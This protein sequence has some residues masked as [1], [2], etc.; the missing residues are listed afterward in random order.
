MERPNSDPAGAGSPGPLDEFTLIE[1]LRARFEAAAGARP[2]SGETWIGD[3]A[4]V[5][6]LGGDRLV[7]STDLVVEGVHVDLALGGPG[8]AGYKALM[9][10]LSDLAAMGARPRYAV[11]SMAAPPGTGLERVGEG[12]ADAAA[13]TG[14]RVV[15]GDLSAAPVLVISVAAVGTLEGRSDSPALLR[16]GATPGDTLFVTG[17]LG[18]AAAGLR[19][20]RRGSACPPGLA[21]RWLRPKARIAQGEAARSAGAVAA[22]DVS[23]GLVA[24]VG[25]LGDASGVGIRLDEVPVEP[26]ATLEDA[27]HGGEDY[28]LVVATGAPSRL[29]VAFEAAG[30]AAPLPIGRCTSQAGE[31][32]HAGV[33]VAPGGWRHSF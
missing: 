26:G 16:S 13:E 6:P 9:V 33:P 11:V 20:L 12:T 25:H 27:L 23:D 17:P 5:V 19:H 28:E 31:R 22:V 4:A 21:A 15:G 24:D 29:V 14:C 7:L 2:P 10:T 8:D 3:D 32:T 1:R 18:G 30:L